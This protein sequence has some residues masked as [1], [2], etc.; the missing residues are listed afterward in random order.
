MPLFSCSCL[1]SL[2]LIPRGLASNSSPVPPSS[3]LGQYSKKLSFLSLTCSFRCTLVYF[4][5]LPSLPPI[6]FGSLRSK[7]CPSYTLV[8]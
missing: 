3:P 8:T 1:T 2:Y 6:D 4:I 7:D 5:A